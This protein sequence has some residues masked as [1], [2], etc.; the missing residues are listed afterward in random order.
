MKRRNFLKLL[1]VGFLA[2]KFGGLVGVLKPE[3][4][5]TLF[6]VEVIMSGIPAMYPTWTTVIPYSD[7]NGNWFLKFP[8]PITVTYV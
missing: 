8:E 7:E 2:A 5:G 1:P 6:Q 3:I 4:V